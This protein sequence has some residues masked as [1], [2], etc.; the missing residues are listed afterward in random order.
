[1]DEFEI[2]IVATYEFAIKVSN[3]DMTKAYE[4]FNYGKRSRQLLPYI[5]PFRKRIP[6]K[7]REMYGWDDVKLNELEVRC[8]EAIRDYP[9]L[10]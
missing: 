7:V 3:L 2:A 6:P 4:S 8:R 9:E 1:M 5:E 10:K